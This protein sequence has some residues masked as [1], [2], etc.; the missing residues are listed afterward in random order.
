MRTHRER[1]R[2]GQVNLKLWRDFS[3]SLTPEELTSAPHLFIGSV[4][5]RISL[6]EMESHIKLIEDVLA[7][8]RQK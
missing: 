5:A 8:R 4:C 3:Q 6:E 2:T 7:E 1:I